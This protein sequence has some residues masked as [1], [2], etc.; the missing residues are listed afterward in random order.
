MAAQKCRKRNKNNKPCG[1]PAGP[2]GLCA[3]HANPERAKELGAK[4]GRGNRHVSADPPEL[5]LSA[6]RDA[7]EV[8]LA[9]GRIMADVHNGKLE[10]RRA[11]TAVYAAT[12][13]MRA[14]ETSDLE[15]R[16]KTLEEKANDTKK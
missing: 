16:V 1:A 3:I 7:A 6:P 10:P 11:T 12:A 4:G 2:N 15:T 13:F 9:L 8:K 5:P 14:L